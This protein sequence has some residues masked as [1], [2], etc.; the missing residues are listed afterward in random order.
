M[1]P[2]VMKHT[3]VT[4]CNTTTAVVCCAESDPFGWCFLQ[5]TV[6]FSLAVRLS[7]TGLEGIVQTETEASKGKCCVTG[8]GADTLN[9][10]EQYSPAS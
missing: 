4:F 7:G 10:L 6:Q 8:G 9:M 2:E 1:S 5:P 3:W